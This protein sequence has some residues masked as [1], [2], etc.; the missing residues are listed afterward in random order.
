MKKYDDVFR[1]IQLSLKDEMKK[2]KFVR[3]MID[4]EEFAE[5]TSEEEEKPKSIKMQ[6]KLVRK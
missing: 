4:I 5:Y 1:M 6:P 3:I 2:L